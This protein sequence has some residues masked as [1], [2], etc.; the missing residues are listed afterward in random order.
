MIGW[1]AWSYWLWEE[2]TRYVGFDH[3]I[4][5]RRIQTAFLA[6]SFLRLVEPLSGTIVV[7]GVNIRSIGLSDL[8]SNITIIPQDPAI[9]S[10]TLRSVLDVFDEHDDAQIYQALRRVH[11]IS[12]QT[13]DENEI[14]E[15][16]FRNLDT[17]VSEGGE[18][19][20]AGQKQLLCMARAILRRSKVVIM[21]EA[22]ASVDYSTD[23]LISRTIKEE[24]V[25]RTVLTIAH[26]LRTVIDYDRVMVLEDG[27]LV[28]LDKPDTLL[29]DPNSH[30]Y[31]LCKATGTKEFSML[32]RMA[33]VEENN[34]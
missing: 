28:E 27:K 31:G 5:V 6:L 33:R 9:L 15:N 20:S 17:P 25:D 8:R 24:F 29:K 1:G 26:R 34:P 19:F 3:V 10:G 18:N 23:E 2:H 7:D 21:D 13:V 22:T 4:H 12:S 32:K 16:V 11:L 30:F 14:N